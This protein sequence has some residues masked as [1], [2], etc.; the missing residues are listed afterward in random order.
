MK[1]YPRPAVTI[2]IILEKEGKL[3]M[4][5]RKKDP[6]KGLLC[7]PG[8]FVN[9][10]EKVECAVKREAYEET[11]LQVEPVEILG[12]YSDPKRD[13]RGHTIS[14]AFIGKIT[15]GAEKAGDDA[16]SIEWISVNDNELQL[17]FDHRRILQDYRHWRKSK[18]TY[19]SSKSLDLIS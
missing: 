7:I 1:N 6:F 12:V 13:P 4:V 2:D 18:G 14:I 10:G 11:N 5:K 17:A 3:L 15:G 19:W 9:V 16:S 8:G